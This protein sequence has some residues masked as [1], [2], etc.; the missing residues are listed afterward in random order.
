MKKD[1]A[2]EEPKLFISYSWSSQDHEAWVV[3]FA[4]ELVSQ[5]INV[6]LDKWDL[7]PGHDANAFMESMVTDP[8]VNKVVLICDEMY[9]TKSDGRA[10]GAGTEAQI[11][12]PKIYAQ[13]N[14]DK[15]V[16]VVTERDTEGKAYLPTYY[17]S[18]IYI[19]LTNAANYGAEF[20]K[21]VRWA[22]G[23]P[24]YARP[25]KGVKPAFLEAERAPGKIASSVA[26]RR[27]CD[28]IRNNSPNVAALTGEYLDIIAEGLESFRIK[29]EPDTR[30][31]F[32]DIVIA[33]IEEF[34]PH[35]NEL[36][37]LFALSAQYSPTSQMAE[38]FH[39]FFEKCLTYFSPPENAG[40][41]SE[42]DFDNYKFIVHEVFLYCIAAFI[43]YEKFAASAFF[44][45]N[46]YYSKTRDSSESA[47]RPFTVFREH[48]RSLEFRNQ[49]LETRRLS[50]RADLLNARS[51]GTGIDFQ[52]VMAA[53]FILYL[54]GQ[55]FELWYGWWPETLLYADRFGGSF[56]MFSRAKSK[57]YFDKIAPL[58]GVSNKAELGE[59]LT[60][61]VADPNR[62]PRWQ[63]ERLNPK[64]LMGFDSLD[65]TP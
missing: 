19:D 11:I 22:W 30:D 34:T 40:G 2:I 1:A 56:E 57:R 38:V 59:V 27:A 60:K 24:L 61:I 47:M 42:W 14:Q 52:Y 62:I 10:G 35:R 31:E 5:G 64:T 39:R 46:E 18:R 26:F 8:S 4:E 43:K 6:I 37:E 53:D 21:I 36:L 7:Q 51:K 45:D 23:Q 41:W 28:A 15:F 17:G 25:E 63:F 33:S 58:L 44:V 48:M 54:R 12:T 16:A 3:K 55:K 20:D 50:I 49:R 13:S 32:D 29:L 65:T 9:A